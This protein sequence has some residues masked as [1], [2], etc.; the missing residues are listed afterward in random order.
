MASYPLVSRASFSCQAE[1]AQ[2]ASKLE[3]ASLALD[4]VTFYMTHFSVSLCQCRHVVRIHGVDL[5]SSHFLSFYA[6]AHMPVRHARARMSHSY[7]RT[8]I[9][10]HALI[11][12]HAA[13]EVLML[14]LSLQS[15]CFTLY[16]MPVVMCVDWWCVGMMAGI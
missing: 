10:L 13:L 14:F 6:R 1:S 12:T 2:L 3:L 7:V 15:I 8:C 5:T 11:R 4:T 16:V 9:R